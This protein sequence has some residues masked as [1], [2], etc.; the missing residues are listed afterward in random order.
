MAAVIREQSAAV[1]A[2][3]GVKACSYFSPRVVLEIDTL[4]ARRSPEIPVV[5]AD[6]LAEVAGRLPE[7]VLAQLRRPL[8][9]SVKVEG[10]RATVVVDAPDEVRRL[11]EQAGRPD[12]V[13]G[14]TPL[15]KIGGRWKVD[16]LKL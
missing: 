14:G 13:G 9:V 11:A 10:D 7:S 6:A 12:A 3:D 4:L 2:G 5:C 1:A 8:L 16:A 15:R